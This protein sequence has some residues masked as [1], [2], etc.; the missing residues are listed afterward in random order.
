MASNPDISL[1]CLEFSSVLECGPKA[2]F[3]REPQPQAIGQ[4]ADRTDAAE[5]EQSE[6]QQA[7]CERSRLL[8]IAH[9]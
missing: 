8:L 5:P 1:E 2:S 4:D 3:G 7:L 9:Q 6:P